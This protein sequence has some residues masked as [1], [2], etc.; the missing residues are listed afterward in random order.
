MFERYTEAARRM[1][2]FARYECSQL[3]ATT[4][5]TE[6]LLLGLIRE[7]APIVRHVLKDANISLEQ[8]RRDV[9]GAT[10]SKPKISTSVEI[11]F[12]EDTRRVLQFAAEEADGLRHSYIG[13]E[14]LLLAM[15]RDERS[16][17]GRVFA[18]HGLA[19]APVR[20]TVCETSG[21][22]NAERGNPL[23]ELAVTSSTPIAELA[24]L[25]RQLAEAQPGSEHTSSLMNQIDILLGRLRLFFGE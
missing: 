13:P 8:L 22:G 2:F 1:L 14:H 15:L 9:E 23:P 18:R 3:G 17:A 7:A 21:D 16:F 11:P 6:H 24:A 5:E 10:A 20:K 4:I 19:L 25:I 12:A